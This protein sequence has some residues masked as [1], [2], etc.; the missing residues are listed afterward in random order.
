MPPFLTQSWA[1]KSNDEMSRHI[2]LKLLNGD[3]H[4]RVRGMQ[5]LTIK[6]DK[7]YASKQI[8][9]KL[10][11]NDI[12]KEIQGSELFS[13]GIGTYRWV[14]GSFLELDIFDQAGNE[15][16]QFKLEQNTKDY[17]K[18]YPINHKTKLDNKTRQFYYLISTFNAIQEI[19]NNVK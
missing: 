9:V 8:H 15:I 4:S 12:I 18:S 16:K 17:V 7:K 10:I 14:F 11:V 2:K 13:E 3:N 19:K 6:T 5:S 1:I